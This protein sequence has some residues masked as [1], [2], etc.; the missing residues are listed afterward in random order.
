MQDTSL[1][2]SKHPNKGVGSSEDFAELLEA[3]VCVELSYDKSS[4]GI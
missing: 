4:T 2:K 1:S 3:S